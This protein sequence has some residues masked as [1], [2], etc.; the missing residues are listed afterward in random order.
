MGE[1]VP[2]SEILGC[3][4]YRAKLTPSRVLWCVSTL[5]QLG[6]LYLIT[7]KMC[8]V[9]SLILIGVFLQSKPCFCWIQLPKWPSSQCAQLKGLEYLMTRTTI[10][11]QSCQRL[12]EERLG[13]SWSPTPSYSEVV[14]Y[15]YIYSCLD[16]GKCE[17]K[18][19]S[20][21]GILISLS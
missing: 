13:S 8:L 15:I 3:R 16:K 12:E 1:G 7:P 6:I 2:S 21:K 17:D 19:F 9:Y 5:G 14:I 18:Y 4:A 11:Y 10:P 20:I